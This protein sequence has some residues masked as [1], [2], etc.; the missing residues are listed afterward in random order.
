MSALLVAAAILP[1]I[2]VIFGMAAGPSRSE[3]VARVGVA[4][5]LAALAIAFAVFTS[6]WLDSPVSAV[7]ENGSGEAVLGLVA[8]RVTSVLLL[9]VLGC[10]RRG[11]G[12]LRPLPER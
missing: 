9:L 10:Q 4:L 7:I 11:P 8:D 12:L 1:G 5:N 6:V 3:A 2:A